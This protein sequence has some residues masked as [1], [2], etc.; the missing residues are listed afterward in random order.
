MSGAAR[1]GS[2]ERGHPV[3]WLAVVLLLGWLG[4]T[5]RA[6]GG[7]Q[8][9][10]DPVQ[11]ERQVMASERV[12]MERLLLLMAVPVFAVSIVVLTRSEVIGFALLAVVVGAVTTAWFSMLR[13]TVDAKRRARMEFLLLLAGV[14]AFAGVGSALSA[15]SDVLVVIGFALLVVLISVMAT[16]ALWMLMQANV[17]VAL[18]S[19]G[20]AV[21][22]WIFIAAVMCSLFGWPA[23]SDRDYFGV[24]AQIN[25]TLL[26]VAA[27]NAA[28]SAWQVTSRVRL[29]WVFSAPTTAVIG[30]GASITG[31]ISTTSAAVLFVLSVSPILPVVYGLMRRVY[32]EVTALD[33]A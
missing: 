22:V 19:F 17:H 28:P 13:R 23:P 6:R 26:V 29:A 25:A 24:A 3:L 14:L 33:R 27:I 8:A 2:R 20:M 30:I 11:R 21:T 1:N 16:Q 4:R 10:G 18:G 15:G 31:Y 7:V 5:R 9:P 12:A 32:I